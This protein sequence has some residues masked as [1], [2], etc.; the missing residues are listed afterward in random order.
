MD[1]TGECDLRLMGYQQLLGVGGP[2]VAA[3]GFSPFGVNFNGSTTL[4]KA[5]DFT[6]NADSSVGIISYWFNGGNQSFTRQ[7][8]SNAASLFTANMAS[9]PAPTMFLQDSLG[10]NQIAFNNGGSGLPASWTHILASWNTNFTSGSRIAQMY[11]QDVSS[12]NVVIDSGTAFNVAY[13]TTAWSESGPS[14]ITADLAEMYFAPGQFL[15]FSITAN[16]RL[17]IS[18]SGHPVDLGATGSTPT[19]VAPILYQS[20]RPAGAANDFLTNRGTGGNMTVSAG[21]LT[22]SGTNP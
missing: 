17:F 11:I 10:V 19:G 4:A 16:R 20:V 12:A 14:F 13:T 21:A 9:S 5:S 1:D 3:A 7:V 6:G 8:L 22:L 18:G 2:P 15:D